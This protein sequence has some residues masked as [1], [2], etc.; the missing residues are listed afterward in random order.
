VPRIAGRDAALVGSALVDGFILYG[1]QENDPRVDT[2]RRRR[3]PYVLVDYAPAPDRR[4]VG[5]DDAA[6]ARLAAEHLV[7]LGH[8]AFGIVMPYAGE[9]MN[10]PQ[11]E[12]GVQR[13][14]GA[15]R[16]A[17][18]RDAVEAAGVDW[19]AVPVAGSEDGSR[20]GG[21]VAAARLLDRAARPTA[22]L[23]FSD[24]LAFGALD[25]A[26]ERGLAVPDRLSVAGFDD[27]PEAALVTP[28]LTTVRQPHL[29]KGSEA[30]RLLLD[31]GGPPS[32]ELPVELVVRAST[33]PAPERSAP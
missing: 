18:W 5:V 16:L 1:T 32:V 21:R 12:R 22:I 6:G 31:E 24:L 13:H 19:E 15:G 27:V 11:A 7:R 23:A 10:G 29:R 17:G 20:A 3:L 2:V 14:V 33:A 8:R 30:V 28:A 9:D 25:A 4:V 26:A